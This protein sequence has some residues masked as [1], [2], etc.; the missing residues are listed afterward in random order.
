MIACKCCK[1]ILKY[2]WT[3]ILLSVFYFDLHVT[4]LLAQLLFWILRDSATTVT[5]PVYVL[6]QETFCKDCCWFWY[7]FLCCFYSGLLVFFYVCFEYSWIELQLM[8][9]MCWYMYNVV[10]VNVKYYFVSNT[11][12]YAPHP[13]PKNTPK[14]HIKMWQRGAWAACQM[15]S[16]K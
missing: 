7:S 12:G 11:T 8:E 15:A 10:A 14:L 5:V 4:G 6:F 2:I 3:S 9:A 1:I 13:C 16:W